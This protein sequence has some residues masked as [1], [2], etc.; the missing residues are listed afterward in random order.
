MPAPSK[1]RRMHELFGWWSPEVKCEDCGR[2]LCTEMFDDVMVELRSAEKHFP[3]M[4][5]P[6]EGI[7]I[8]EEEVGELWQ[9]ITKKE[10]DAVAMRKE[11]IQVAAM[12]CRFLKDLCSVPKE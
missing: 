1:M 6:H 11:A 3:P 12:A 7:A 4:R 8:L 10:H 2:L 9:E 5:S